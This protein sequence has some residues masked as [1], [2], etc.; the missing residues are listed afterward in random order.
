VSDEYAVIGMQ[1]AL[2]GMQR[3][4]VAAPALCLQRAQLRLERLCR[5]ASMFALTNALRCGA[6]TRLRLARHDLMSP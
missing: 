6:I 1:R 5:G 2:V 3:A 4:L